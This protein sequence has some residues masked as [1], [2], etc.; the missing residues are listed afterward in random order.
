MKMTDVT[1]VFLEFKPVGNFHWIV[2]KPSTFSFDQMTHGHINNRFQ[3]IPVQNCADGWRSN[4]K[5]D[6]SLDPTKIVKCQYVNP[7]T[8][9]EEDVDPQPVELIASEVGYGGVIVTLGDLSPVIQLT[10]HPQN[11]KGVFLVTASDNKV[12]AYCILPEAVKVNNY[13]QLSFTTPIIEITSTA[14]TQFDS[15]NIPN[16]Q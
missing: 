6:Y 16:T 8:E 7:N 2:N 9:Q 13:L 4:I 5:P 10:S 11:L 12:L 1:S 14:N 3:F 15:N